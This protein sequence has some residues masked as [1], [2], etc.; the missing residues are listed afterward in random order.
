MPINIPPAKAGKNWHDMPNAGSCS[1]WP[2]RWHLVMGKD[3]LL[4]FGGDD[5]VNWLMMPPI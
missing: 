4:I 1:R 2:G 3:E 5:G